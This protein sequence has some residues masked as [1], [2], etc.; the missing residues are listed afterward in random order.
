MSLNCLYSTKFL[1]FYSIYLQNLGCAENI[2]SALPLVVCIR[3]DSG[4]MSQEPNDGSR[5]PDRSKP[6]AMSSPIIHL[7]D[8]SPYETRTQPSVH[9]TKHV[10]Q[11]HKTENLPQC[12]SKLEVLNE[13]ATPRLERIKRAT[14]Q[15]NSASESSNDQAFS[16]LNKELEDPD[17]TSSQLLSTKT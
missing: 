2:F 5:Q 7:T 16:K 1:N 14:A 9:N 12:T 13:E 11:T 8:W 6:R 17:D 15:D 3:F 4:G 10:S